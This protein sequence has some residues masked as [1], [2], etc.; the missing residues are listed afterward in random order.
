MHWETSQNI[1]GLSEVVYFLNKRNV[2]NVWLHYLNF[3]GVR[4]IAK[5]NRN[6]KIQKIIDM[7]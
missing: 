7:L 4:Q 1:S 5:A 3:A 6:Y 2:F